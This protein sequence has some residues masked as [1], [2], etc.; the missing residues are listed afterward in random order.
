[1]RN[2]LAAIAIVACTTPALATS[3]IDCQSPDGSAGVNLVMGT[4][5][6]AAVVAA[7][8]FA[9]DLTMRLARGDMMVGQQF[10]GSQFLWIDFVDPNVEKILVELRLNFADGDNGSAVAGTL[11]IADHGAYPVI[12][13]GP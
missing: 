13:E 2:A 11:R 9:G 12:C 3:S 5:P 4:L 7:N 1:M 8:V 6:V 10:A